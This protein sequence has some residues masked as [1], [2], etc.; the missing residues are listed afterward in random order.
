[1]FI[2]RALRLGHCFLFVSTF[3]LLPL[4]F[5]FTIVPRFVPLSFRPRPNNVGNSGGVCYIPHYCKLPGCNFAVQCSSLKLTT[6]LY[7]PYVPAC[8][9][10]LF[11][12]AQMPANM[13]Q[14]WS[15]SNSMVVMPLFQC[16]GHSLPSRGRAGVPECSL[17]QLCLRALFDPPRPRIL[18]HTHT[19]TYCGLYCSEQCL[20]SAELSLT[21]IYFRTPEL[22]TNAAVAELGRRS[23]HVGQFLLRPCTAAGC[24]LVSK[25]AILPPS[26]TLGMCL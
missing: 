17:C 20:L 25:R 14:S 8:V 10:V 19:H 1:M 2:C 11:Q 16:P 9:H 24:W 18:T 6:F 22:A 4:L 23:D 13:A 12:T 7:S 21:L 15:S 3:V 5:S 26:K